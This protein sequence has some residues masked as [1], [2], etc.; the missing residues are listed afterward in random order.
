M[1]A[2]ARGRYVV[3]GEF[4]LDMNRV[5]LLRGSEPLAVPPRA[6]DT[7][8]A[9]VGHRDRVV[10]KEELLDLI[11]PDAAV[12]EANLAQQVFTLRRILGDDP[13]HPRF[14]ATLPRR[15]YRFVADATEETGDEGAGRAAPPPAAPTNS[16]P[17]PWPARLRLAGWVTM[18]AACG[19][20]IGLRFRIPTAGALTAAVPVAFDVALPRGVT[21]DNEAGIAGVSPDGHWLGFVARGEEGPTMLFVRRMDGRETRRLPGTDGATAPFW[22]PDSRRLGYFAQGQL[23]TIAVDGGVPQ[24]VCAAPDHRGGAWGADE[25][26]LF[27]SGSRSVIYRVAAG[28]GAPVAVTQLHPARRDISHRFPAFLPDGRRFVFLVW[29]GDVER[30]G[31]YLGD[32]GHPRLTRLLPDASP[33][34]W[35]RGRLL[36]VRRE[37]LLALAVDELTVAPVGDAVTIAT[38]VAR[39]PS[40]SAAFAATAAGAIAFV[41]SRFE[42]RLAWFDRSGRE[43][44]EVAGPGQYEGPAVSAD[45]RQLLFSHRDRARGNENLDVWRSD[46]SG[47][48]RTRIT[49]AGSVDI[50]PTWSPDGR[51]VLFRSNRSG[52]SDIYR[53]RLDSAAAETL[54]FASKARKDPTDWSPDGRTIVFT[55]ELPDRTSDIWQLA[56]DGAARPRPLVTGPGNQRGG[57]YSP[58]GRFLAYDSDEN[59]SL[60]VFVQAVES[61]GDRW[62]VA[63]GLQPAW[64]RRGAELLFFGERGI[65]SVTVS[66]AGAGL[67]FSAPRPLFAIERA[68]VVRNA[69]APAPDGSRVLAIVPL[70]R[71][72]APRL[73]VTLDWRP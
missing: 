36:F 12:E 41:R 5:R 40:D 16:L 4:R 70:G 47:R 15:G 49:F 1:T 50:E 29:S 42:A 9:L 13:D 71:E 58:D 8:V 48:D 6:L 73:T 26:L 39:S 45:G 10:P 35:S 46:A 67:T 72:D 51:D 34:V 55:A 18:A 22:S 54:V 21:L 37:S 32:L 62:R 19:L 63:R 14:I 44:E 24:D 31:I 11:W 53:R 3:F 27:A 66:E 64:T 43:L 17:S 57:R 65:E 59:G 7:L 61:H 2:G 33:A 69:F 52:Y 20:A 68:A 23:R 30:Q 38:P 60:E 28:G 56:L 25:V